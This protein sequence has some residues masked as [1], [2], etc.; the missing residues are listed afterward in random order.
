MKKYQRL[1]IVSLL[2]GVAFF[3]SCEDDDEGRFEPDPPTYSIVEVETDFGKMYLY[4]YDGT[5]IHKNNFLALADSGFYDGTEFHRV[6]PNFV[7]Q[8]GDPNSKDDDRT[9]DGRGGPGYTLEAEIDTPRYTHKFGALASARLSD[10]QNPQRRSSGSQFYIVVDTLGESFLDGSYTVFG[11]VISGMDAAL[12]IAKQP[13][14]V[15]T[16]RPNERIKMNMTILQKTD[17]E[18]KEEFNFTRPK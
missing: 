7:V 11:E 9:N 15:Q 2:M 12:D 10:I 13:R 5:P 4:L 16:D 6:V 17:D 18:L 8:G 3:Y 1:L 14:D